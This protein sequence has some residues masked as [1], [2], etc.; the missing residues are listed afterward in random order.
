MRLEGRRGRKGGGEGRG[1]ESAARGWR[2][3]G[4]ERKGREG[5]D[6][7]QGY[8]LGGRHCEEDRKELLGI[9]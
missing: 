5:K 9:G 7:R 3:T 6:E 2:E 1:E 4:E 8:L